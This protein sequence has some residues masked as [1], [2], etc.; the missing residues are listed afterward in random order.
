MCSI[1]FERVEYGAHNKIYYNLLV[2]ACVLCLAGTCLSRS[3]VQTVCWVFWQKY[4]NTPAV[5]CP[6]SVVN[7]ESTSSLSV[8]TNV[9]AFD[10]TRLICACTHSNPA[11]STARHL[12]VQ[13]VGQDRADKSGRTWAHDVIDL[14]FD[15]IVRCGYWR[16]NYRTLSQPIVRTLIQ[17]KKLPMRRCQRIFGQ[18]L[19]GFVAQYQCISHTPFNGQQNVHWWFN[20]LMFGS[21]ICIAIIHISC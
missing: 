1:R 8:M 15:S 18:H 21:I 11:A 5:C 12:R 2:C 3:H 6:L 20:N 14:D 4:R 10:T 9:F 7:V 13:T 17:K 19:W 16:L